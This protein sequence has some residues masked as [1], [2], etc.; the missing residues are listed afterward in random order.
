M[1]GEWYHFDDSV[2]EVAQSIGMAM[3]DHKQLP[4]AEERGFVVFG[5]HYCVAV[6]D[7]TPTMEHLGAP[8]GEHVAT[9]A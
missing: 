5:S 1:N 4:I 6:L 3:G 8:M 7:T 9:T 2:A